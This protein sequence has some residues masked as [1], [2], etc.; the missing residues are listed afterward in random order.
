VQGPGFDTSTK[1][2]KKNK[3]G[4]LEQHSHKKPS[5]VFKQIYKG[6]LNGWRG[7]HGLF[8]NGSFILFN[9]CCNTE[10]ARDNGPAFQALNA[11]KWTHGRLSS[12]ALR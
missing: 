3:P 7:A 6:P 11:Y 2:E 12:L 1:K 8:L 4:Q 5:E 9:P 10:Q